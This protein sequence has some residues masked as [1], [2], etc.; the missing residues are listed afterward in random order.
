MLDVL[1]LMAPFFGL[2]ALGWITAR[3]GLLP[4]D[5]IGGLMTFV[6]Y[7]AL[8]AL[9]LRL[10]AQGRLQAGAR[11]V[12]MALARMH[13][14]PLQADSAQQVRQAQGELQA[15]WDDLL[16]PSAFRQAVPEALQQRWQQEA[17]AVPLDR[18]TEQ[19]LWETSR[20]HVDRLAAKDRMR[21]QH[22]R[23]AEL[24]QFG[25]D[26]QI[27]ISIKP[28]EVSIICSGGPGTHSVH[29]P[30]FGHT[31]SVTQQII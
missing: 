13:E 22:T 31:R 20:L 16:A 23:G 10:A 29:V 21:L 26:T 3:R 25:A 15:A 7:F 2:V 28:E 14:H 6:L 12:A 11:Q 24:G 27:P 30:T 9:L 18:K 19:K 8:S 5:G 1:A 17:Q 4:V